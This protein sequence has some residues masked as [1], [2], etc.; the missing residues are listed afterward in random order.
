MKSYIQKCRQDNSDLRTRSI[1]FCFVVESD[2]NIKN[3]FF[4]HII[5]ME[6]RC[7]QSKLF[8]SILYKYNKYRIFNQERP[9]VTP[10][11]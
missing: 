5:F 6:I 7:K 4:T 1:F 10:I 9:Q 8:S 3:M 2:F 11:R